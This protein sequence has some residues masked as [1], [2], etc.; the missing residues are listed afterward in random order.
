MYI[1]AQF[2]GGVAG[3]LLARQLI[4]MSLGEKGVRYVVTEPGPAGTLAALGAEVTIAFVLMSMVLTARASTRWSRHTGLFAGAL[5][6]L[7]ITFESPLSGMSLNPARTT[8]SAVVASSWTAIWI[9]FLAPLGG[10]LLAARV[11]VWR[12]RPVPCGKYAH[13]TPC[14]FCEHAAAANARREAAAQIG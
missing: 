10:M 1:V 3:V 6:A 8:A 12:R 11:H 9:Y 5:V 13:G 7:Y 14:I 2:V 4:G